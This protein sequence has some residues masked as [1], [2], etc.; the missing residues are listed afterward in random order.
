MYFFKG[1]SNDL[2]KKRPGVFFKSITGKNVQ[3]LYIKLEPGISTFHSHPNE[4]MGYI[5]SGEVE[6]TI[7][8]E[9]VTLKS[10]DAYY[11]PS[12]KEHGFKVL[13]N[14]NLEYIE[15]FCP[16]KEDNI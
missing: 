15:V 13:N 6:L 3:L 12:N 5:L 7:E 11:M 9:N 2:K 10:G 1:F 8:G 16:I 4:Q 14:E